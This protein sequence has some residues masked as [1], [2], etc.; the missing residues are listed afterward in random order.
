MK[1]S[2][3][4][5]SLAAL[6]TSA[7]AG[8]VYE[9]K[10]DNGQG[11][12]NVYGSA[13][14]YGKHVHNA[15]QDGS[16]TA[17]AVAHSRDL[18]E[19]T[20][21]FELGFEADY[22]D[23]NGLGL[24]VDASATYDSL[25]WNRVKFDD[26]DFVNSHGWSQNGQGRTVDVD[27]AFG[28]LHLGVAGDFSYG[29]QG[30]AYKRFTD[31]L[32]YLDN[33]N[34]T[35]LTGTQFVQTFKYTSPE[36]YGVKLQ[37]SYGRS[38]YNSFTAEELADPRK[39]QERKNVDGLRTLNYAANLSGYGVTVAYAHSRTVKKEDTS[40][41]FEGYSND[42]SVQYVNSTLAE[43]LDLGLG[44]NYAVSHTSTADNTKEDRKELLS[45]G[46][47]VSYEGFQY[48]KP[49]AGVFASRTVAENSV[50]KDEAT[51]NPNQVLLV[52][53][54]VGFATTPVKYMDAELTLFVEGS[55]VQGWNRTYTNDKYV[56]KKYAPTYAGAFGVSLSW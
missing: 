5:L 54:Y 42:V 51:A 7:F 9:H 34:A 4:A 39:G 55:Y 47:K 6:A 56:T 40:T 30:T 1:K 29:N 3:L 2:V 50:K 49:Y 16:D 53:P 36:F 15:K 20:A 46:L 12:L 25:T 43:G 17:V 26:R 32:V 19:V 48:A 52:Q 10:D 24:G 31:D 22:K 21:N 14:F 11:F 27:H 28:T 41:G 45:G 38:N 8:N 13:N 35:K 18:Q 44:V 33:Y 37:A 23:Q